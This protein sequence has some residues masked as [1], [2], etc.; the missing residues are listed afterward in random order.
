MALCDFEKQVSVQFVFV[1]V[2]PVLLSS[3][4]GKGQIIHNNVCK[5]PSSTPAHS[6]DIKQFQHIDNYTVL[7]TVLILKYYVVKRLGLK[8]FTGY[9]FF[10][11]SVKSENVY[12]DCDTSVII[13]IIIN[14]ISIVRRRMRIVLSRNPKCLSLHVVV[15]LAGSYRTVVLAYKSLYLWSGWP[16]CPS[17][18]QYPYIER[19][20]N[21]NRVQYE[22]FL[23]SRR[24]G[25]YQP[26]RIKLMLLK[27]EIETSYL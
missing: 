16:R 6:A 1:P 17:V 22:H 7:G 9:I 15:G 24:G 25:I 2:M 8:L 10:V 20:W 18:G 12:G 27:Q 5:H 3:P 13:I 21:N 11:C 4:D 14:S 26:Q 19:S 23:R